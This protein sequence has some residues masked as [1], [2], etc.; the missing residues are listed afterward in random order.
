[1]VVPQ[2]LTVAK[3]GFSHFAIEQDHSYRVSIRETVGDRPQREVDL[4][5]DFAEATVHQLRSD[6]RPAD[7]TSP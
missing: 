1:V 3:K 6:R 7:E 2:R 4:T 5:L